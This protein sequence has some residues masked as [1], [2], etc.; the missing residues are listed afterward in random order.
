MARFLLLISGATSL[1]LGI[2]GVLLPL[3]PTVPFVLLAAFCFARSSPRLEKW[4]L[5]HER[6]GPH[7]ASWRT[8]RSISRSGKV[9]AWTAF[10]ISAAIGLLTLPAYWN[11][12]PL[13]VGV[14]GS[15]FIARVRTVPQRG[16][17]TASKEAGSPE[18]DVDENPL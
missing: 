13:A 3:L 17:G 16:L 14:G 8:S 15:I 6:F 11:V 18:H 4:L 9:A 12:I 2:L 10:A 1:M 7:I 5:E